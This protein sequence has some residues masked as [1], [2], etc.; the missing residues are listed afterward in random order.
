VEGDSLYDQMYGW[1]YETLTLKRS[2]GRSLNRHSATPG[3]G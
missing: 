3:M 2:Q 1:L